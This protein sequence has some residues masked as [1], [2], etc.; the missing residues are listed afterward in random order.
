MY[1]KKIIET[2]NFFLQI[3]SVSIWWK[4][5]I[6]SPLRTAK[7]VHLEAIKRPIV[8]GQCQILALLEINWYAS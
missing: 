1:R 2:Y 7:R 4:L 5:G 6:M 8:N 3:I